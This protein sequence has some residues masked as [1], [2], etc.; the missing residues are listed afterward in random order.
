MLVTKTLRDRRRRRVRHDAERTA[1]RD[2]AR[3]RQ[4]D[5]P[6]GRRGLHAGAADRLADDIL[7]QRQ[8]IHRGCNQRRVVH[9][10]SSSHSN[11]RRF[12]AFLAGADACPPRFSPHISVAQLST[13]ASFPLSRT[14]TVARQGVIADAMQ[15]SSLRWLFAALVCV[16]ALPTVARAQSAIGGTVKDTS[17]AVLPGVT[18]E[19]ASDV[20][21]EKTQVGVDRRPGRSTRSSTCGPASTPSR[22]RCRASTP[23]SVRRS[24]CRRTSPPPSTPSMKVGALEESVTVSGASPVVD[25]QS[26]AKTQV[27]SRDVLDAVPSA[28]D[29][30][31]PRPAGRRRDAVVARRR[32]LARDAA[33]LLRGARRRRLGRDGHR[34]RPGH[35]RQHGRRRGDGVS[36]RGDDPGSGLPDRGRHRR[37]DH[38]RH[39]HEPRAEG[40]RQPLRRRAE[41]R[42]VAGAAG[43]ATT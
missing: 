18:V 36:Q 16:I 19:V 8:A 32:R 10:A 12:H 23:S 1:R 13:I 30:S 7:L 20:L 4:G 5:G 15:A 29:D 22:S 24:S 27:L 11:F 41:V 34:R 38:R 21:I 35:Q 3:V 17:G 40:R 42:Q 26:N 25:V 37:D 2:A 33:D 6:G 31:E 14:R 39:Q 28:Q 9:A 43:R